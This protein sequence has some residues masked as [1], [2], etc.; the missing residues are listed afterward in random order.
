MRSFVFTFLTIVLMFAFNGAARADYFLWEDSKTGLSFTFP[1]TWQVVQNADPEDLLTVMAPGG[2]GHAQC[3]IR[4][5]IDGRYKI[6][7]PRYDWA[8]QKIDFSFDFWNKYLKEY[9]N[10]EIVSIQNGAGLGRGYA[11]YAVAEY[12]G[13]VPGPEMRRKGLMFVS[14]YHDR[15]F[16]LDCSSHED[17]FSRWKSLF[18]S[19]A[20]SV[21]YK[22]THYEM[23][24]GNYRNFLKDS[25]II[26][27]GTEGEEVYSY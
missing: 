2:R 22:K 23:T 19:V 15:Q 18:L 4:S 16:V 25:D 8:I 11:G 1:D 5:E 3:R 17:A 27:K 21:D 10:S 14:L 7:P 12:V 20:G 9:Q 24:T 26:L 6:Y 13:E